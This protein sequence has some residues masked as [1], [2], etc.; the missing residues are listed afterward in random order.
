[1]YAVDWPFF[2]GRFLVDHGHER[3]QVTPLSPAWRAKLTS[4]AAMAQLS[5]CMAAA[6]AAHG[7][8]RAQ[9][10]ARGG[11]DRLVR[12]IRTASVRLRAPSLLNTRRR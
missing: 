6:V 9:G 11:P 4:F 12:M 5:S 1:M 2:A 8:K 3:G 7:G 10:A